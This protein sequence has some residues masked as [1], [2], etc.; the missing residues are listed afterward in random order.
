MAGV[1]PEKGG[2]R[3]GDGDAATRQVIDLLTAILEEL[4]KQVKSQSPQPLEGPA[5]DA[6]D[7]FAEIHLRLGR[8]SPA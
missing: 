5:K 8:I 2:D 1:Y 6:A 3:P 7:K 4:R